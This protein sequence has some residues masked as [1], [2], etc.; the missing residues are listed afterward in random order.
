MRYLN[1]ADIEKVACA[2]LLLVLCHALL[3]HVQG[4]VL[5][6]ACDTEDEQWI[7]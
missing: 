4:A 3:L 2:F 5:E 7:D 6:V 1:M